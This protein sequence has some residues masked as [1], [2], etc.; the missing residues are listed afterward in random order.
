M[1]IKEL[2]GEYAPKIIGRKHLIAGRDPDFMKETAIPK[3]HLNF[4]VVYVQIIFD[5]SQ[6]NEMGFSEADH[7]R[8]REIWEKHSTTVQGKLVR[9]EFWKKNKT[10]PIYDL[11]FLMEEILDALGA[12]LDV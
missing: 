12:I 11:F 6:N 9:E 3:K 1:E 7:D 2:W 5:L 10:L 4:L 8:M